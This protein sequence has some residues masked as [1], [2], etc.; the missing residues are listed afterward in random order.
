MT[1]RQ[2]LN[3]TATPQ[4]LRAGSYP[5]PYSI[6]NTSL[7]AT[8]WVANNPAVA[9]FQGTSIPPSTALTWTPLDNEDLYVVL[10][11]DGASILAGAA[12]FIVS[13]DTTGWQ[14]DPSAVATATALAILNTGSLIIDQPQVLVTN[15][16]L[17]SLSTG[18]TPPF[19]QVFDVRRYSSVNIRL[20]NTVAAR[21]TFRIDFYADAACTQLVGSGLTLI[22]FSNTN[23]EWLGTIPVMG[24]YM[25]FNGTTPASIFINSVSLSYR[26]VPGI[27]QFSPNLGAPSILTNTQLVN[28][29]AFGSQIF[30]QPWYG[31]VEIIQ[32]YDLTA[33]NINLWTQLYGFSG[34]TTTNNAH[35]SC[36][37]SGGGYLAEGHLTIIKQVALWGQQLLLLPG[38]TSAVNVTVTT[39]V[40]PVRMNP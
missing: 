4:I 17:S 14:P 24:A 32:Q 30:T 9:P 8:I 31:L 3:L 6:I 5:G 16:Y 35:L 34:V 18:V 2:P 37:A 36:D 38:N 11:N 12:P 27:R 19:F 25:V 26:S 21:N 33:F 20:A 13:F 39:Q 7:T 28:S 23:A 15:A 1:V 40:S 29:G 10:G 22:W